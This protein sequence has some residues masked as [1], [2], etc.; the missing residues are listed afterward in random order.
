MRVKVRDSQYDLENNVRERTAQLEAGNADLEAFSYS[1]S[2]D[3]R[4]PLRAMNGFSRILLESHA[5]DLPPEAIRYLNSIRENASHMGRLIDDLLAFSQLG[6][7]ELQ[8]QPI[9]SAELVRR[10]FDELRPEIGDR[11]VVLSVGDLWRRS[12]SGVAASLCKPPFNAIKYLA[13][14]TRRISRSASKMV[15]P[16]RDRLLFKGRR[17]R[18]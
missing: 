15:E 4:A 3:L 5:N 7:K 1:V 11:K 12:R 8:R 14:G 16:Q 2:H 9:A 18:L 10:V 13:A 6:R 17:R